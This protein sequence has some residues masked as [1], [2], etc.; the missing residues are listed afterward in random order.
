MPRSLTEALGIPEDR[1]SKLAELHSKAID[2]AKAKAKDK[3]SLADVIR[4]IQSMADSGQ[5]SVLE[6]IVMGFITGVADVQLRFVGG[7]L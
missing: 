7:L 3:T 2:R 1:V 4:E 6:A 5:I